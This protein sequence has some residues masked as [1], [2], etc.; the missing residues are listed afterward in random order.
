MPIVCSLSR[1][2]QRDNRLQRA[3]AQWGKSSRQPS[4]TG[5]GAIFIASRDFDADDATMVRWGWQ[6][7]GGTFCRRYAEARSI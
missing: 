3:T 5:L 1:G 2:P 6:T 4:E 7:I